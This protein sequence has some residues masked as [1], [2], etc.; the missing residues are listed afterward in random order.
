[1]NDDG[2]NFKNR[3]ENVNSVS[4]KIIFFRIHVSSHS[5][6]FLI[7]GFY[8]PPSRHH[9]QIL[10]PF[11]CGMCSVAYKLQEWWEP[12][13]RWQTTTS[14]TIPKASP[15][16]SLNRFILLNLVTINKS[17]LPMVSPSQS[18]K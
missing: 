12:M 5:F 13:V 18:P 1:V 7:L 16:V 17:F 3:E 11:L 15:T 9:S 8:T 6:I 14:E 4:L 10:G 2:S